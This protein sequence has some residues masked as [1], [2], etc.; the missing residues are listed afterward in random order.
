VFPIELPALRERPEDIP[1]L[2]WAFVKEFS[3]SMG[4][5]IEK[6]AGDSMAAMRAYPWP[7]NIRELRNVIERAMILAHGPILQ[8]KLGHRRQAQAVKPADGTL[9]E[10]ERAH[11]VRALQR[12]NWRVRGSHG[13]AEQLDIKPTTLEL[14]MKKLGITGTF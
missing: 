10:A 12:C 11:I 9:V 6:I 13:A 7:G 2:S 1:L 14:R 8:V 3:N 4:K 5:P